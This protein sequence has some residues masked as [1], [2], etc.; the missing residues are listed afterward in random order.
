ML[1]HMFGNPLVPVFRFDD[2]FDPPVERTGRTLTLDDEAFIRMLVKDMDNAHST[3]KIVEGEENIHLYD[4]KRVVRA[5]ENA[6]ERGV[7][8]QFVLK[9]ALNGVVKN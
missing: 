3:V 4:D 8:I 5:F 1:D 7:K 2:M 9:P 6:V